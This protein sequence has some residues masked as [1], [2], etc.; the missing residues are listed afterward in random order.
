M[1]KVSVASIKSNM[2]VARNIYSAS[3]KLLLGRGIRLTDNYVRRLVEMKVPAVYVESPFLRDVDVPEML[4][5]ETRVRAVK[6]IIGAFCDVRSKSLLG[7][8][9]A[10]ISRIGEDIVREIMSN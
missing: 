5:E 10:S 4:S 1:Q 8:S 7:G 3:G 6:Q 9:A 2:V